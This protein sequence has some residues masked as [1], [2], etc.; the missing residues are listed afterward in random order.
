[1]E[2]R[3][4]QQRRAIEPTQG[5]ERDGAKRAVAGALEPQ[6]MPQREEESL[7]ERSKRGEAFAEMASSFDEVKG[8]SEHRRVRVV[9]H[10]E[11]QPQP[12][13]PRPRGSCV[14]TA[15]GLE[16]RPIIPYQTGCESGRSWVH[17]PRPT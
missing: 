1:M 5:E 2:E 9:A 6:S 16:A 8:L 4:Q 13:M 11:V 10:S 7:D 3:P 14:K 17:T 15:N 12:G